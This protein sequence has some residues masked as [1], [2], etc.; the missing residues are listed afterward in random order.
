M[1]QGMCKLVGKPR[2]CSY[3][4]LFRHPRPTAFFRSTD[5]DFLSKYQ[6]EWGVLHV[7]PGKT[8]GHMPIFGLR[9]RS[10]P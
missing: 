10:Y 6:L 9:S 5:V 8:A 7:T 1:G 4:G 3:P 2:S